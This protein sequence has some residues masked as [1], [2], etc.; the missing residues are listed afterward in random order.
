MARPPKYKTRKELEDKIEE[1]F[2]TIEEEKDT[3]T[4]SGLCYH[5]GFASRQSFYDMEKNKELSYTI[6]RARLA[7]EVHYEKLVQTK[8]PTGAIFALK[9]FGWRDKTETEIS[10]GETPVRVQLR[11]TDD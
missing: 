5:L 7:I 6:K 9:N 8:T 4:I 1:Y 10:G 11:P 3:L 2:S